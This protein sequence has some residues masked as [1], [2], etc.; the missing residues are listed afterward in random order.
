GS[1]LA[2][3]PGSPA[4]RHQRVVPHMGGHF[5]QRA[6]AI[7]FR[8]LD[9]GAYLRR[10]PAEP[11]HLGWREMPVVRARRAVQNRRILLE[12]A[13]CA[14]QSGV[15]ETGAVLAPLDIEGVHA[16]LPIMC[17]GPARTLV[18]DVAVGAAGMRE[19]GIDPVPFGKP[20]RP[21]D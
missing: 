5:L 13:G 4:P 12:M 21:I 3:R 15:A 19:D 10:R 6:A 1:G 14:A 16:G 7:A 2:T 11:H 17:A 9:L 20:G 8:V 18:L